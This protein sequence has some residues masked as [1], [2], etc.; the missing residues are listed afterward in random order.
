[1]SIYHPHLANG[2]LVGGPPSPSPTRSKKRKRSDEEE[3]YGTPT[4]TRVG[5]VSSHM[6]GLPTPNE[7]GTW[8]S[9][10]EKVQFVRFSLISMINP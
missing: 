1:M 8:A 6:L 10:P 2:S 9:F 4:K 5:T 3:D 7:K